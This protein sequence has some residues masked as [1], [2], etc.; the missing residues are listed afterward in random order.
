MVFLKVYIL[1]LKT[2]ILFENIYYFLRLVPYS[3]KAVTRNKKLSG[4]FNRENKHI[5]PDSES[6]EIFEVLTCGLPRNL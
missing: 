4:V 3:A 1:T 2:T 6:I 5:P